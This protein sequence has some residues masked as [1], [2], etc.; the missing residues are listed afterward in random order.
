MGL[1]RPMQI[2]ASARPHLVFAVRS[3][4]S[5]GRRYRLNRGTNATGVSDA[6]MTGLKAVTA[7]YGLWASMTAFFFASGYRRSA[8][9]LPSTMTLIQV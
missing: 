7:F 4:V 1:A 2:R 6:A 8:G 3:A 9:M 5:V